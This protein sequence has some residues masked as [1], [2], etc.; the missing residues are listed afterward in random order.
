MIT[1]NITMILYHSKAFTLPFYEQYKLHF[2]AVIYILVTLQN[3]IHY[4]CFYVHL[5]LNNGY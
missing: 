1:I 3:N 5:L 2:T 4:Q